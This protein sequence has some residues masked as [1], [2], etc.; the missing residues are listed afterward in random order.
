MNLNVAAHL[1]DLL[2][3]FTRQPL[4]PFLAG[5]LKEKINKKV[6]ELKVT[7]D[8]RHL[9]GRLLYL[10]ATN[11]IYLESVFS[12]LILPKPACFAYPDGTI[13]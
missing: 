4:L 3:L 2:N 10:S 8:T 12:F 13:R 11:R 7:K 6:A 9:F 5:I 1:I